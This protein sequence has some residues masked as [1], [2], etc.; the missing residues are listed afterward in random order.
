MVALGPADHRAPKPLW[1]AMA[2]RFKTCSPN[3]SSDS[4]TLVL[5][6]PVGPASTRK[7]YR[8]GSKLQLTQHMMAP[9]FVAAAQTPCRPTHFVEDMGERTTAL[10]STPAVDQ[11]TPG[12]GCAAGT[13]SQCGAPHCAQYRA[14][15]TGF[16]RRHLFVQRTHPDAF[17]SSN[18]GQLIAPG[19]WL[20]R[21]L[22]RRACTDHG[23]ETA[24]LGDIGEGVVDGSHAM[25]PLTDQNQNSAHHREPCPPPGTLCRGPSEVPPQQR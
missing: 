24:Q 11:R 1:A 22:T 21:K 20:Q 5:P 23:T 16:K 7:S 2:S 14:Y 19:I 15:L 25:F 12:L 17:S 13:E 6:E 4:R 9:G 10:P 18:T 3:A 8:A